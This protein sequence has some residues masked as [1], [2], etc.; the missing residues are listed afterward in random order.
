MAEGG[1]GVAYLAGARVLVAED[2]AVIAFEIAFEIETALRELGC[3]VLGPAAATADTLGLVA[4]ERPDAALLDV[5]LL[6]GS[7]AAA[8]AARGV[9]FALVTGYGEDEVTEPAFA[10]APRLAKP[11]AAH[12]LR[13]VLAALLASR[14]VE[15]R[16][17]PGA[18]GAARAEPPFER[19]ARPT[20]RG[21]PP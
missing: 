19:P 14:A 18:P 17:A 16:R 11:F 12:E 7:A 21:C 10:A 8:C 9:P 5:E 2:E 13:R 6:D 3:V 15:P 1:L 4:R 20:G